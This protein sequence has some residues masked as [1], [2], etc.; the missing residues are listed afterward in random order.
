MIQMVEKTPKNLSF[1]IV[2]MTKMC[3][4][5][6]AAYVIL[7]KYFYRQQKSCQLDSKQG[8]LW[9]V[10]KFH[11]LTQNRLTPPIQ[12][13]GVLHI[14]YFAK[15]NNYGKQVFFIYQKS[16][17]TLNAHFWY[18]YNWTSNSENYRRCNSKKGV[19]FLQYYAEKGLG[20]CRGY[21]YNRDTILAFAKLLTFFKKGNGCSADQL[22]IYQTCVY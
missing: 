13:N 19:P 18:M 10:S 1:R 6:L 4:L 7:P 16:K 9:T 5:Y 14:Q 17:T 8:L 12:R 15:K 2:Y 21:P 22:Y 11:M 20:N 3:C